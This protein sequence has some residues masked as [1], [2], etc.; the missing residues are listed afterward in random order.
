M[1]DLRKR[2]LIIDDQ[3]V[4][5]N[6][7][8]RQLTP[9]Y[10]VESFD[11]PNDAM[12]AIAAMGHR[13]FDLIISDNDL[14]HNVIKGF[15]LI[16]LIKMRCDVPCILYTGDTLSEIEFGRHHLPDRI[17]SK[18]SDLLDGKVGIVRAVEELI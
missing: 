8:R 17:V 11:N 7:L 12:A 9:M 1:N 6:A 4:E 18:G 10:D 15:R 16:D 14:G 5:L 2:I 13:S 3:Q